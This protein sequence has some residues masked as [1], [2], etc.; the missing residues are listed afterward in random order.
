MVIITGK[1]LPKI[2]ERV[3]LE[4]YYQFFT[5]MNNSG[6]LE[7]FFHRPFKFTTDKNKQNVGDLKYDIFQ[8]CLEAYES[9]DASN[10]EF[11]CLCDDESPF[12]SDEILFEEKT[13]NINIVA[14]ARIRIDEDNIHIPEILFLDYPDQKEKEKRVIGS[15]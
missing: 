3:V 14:V 11:V 9:I 7:R 12:E 13:D 15:S 4:E 10:I 8:D 6:A 5:R 2:Y 1:R